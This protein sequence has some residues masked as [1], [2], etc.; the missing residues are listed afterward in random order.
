MPC[1][2]NTIVLV[3]MFK[4]GAEPMTAEQIMKQ[5]SRLGDESYKKTMLRHGASGPIFGVKIEELKKIQ[6]AIKKDYK[7]ALELFDSGNSDAMYLAGLIADEQ[8]MTKKDLEHWAATASWHMI[9]EYTVSWVA[10][11]SKFGFEL[12]KKWIDSKK[13]KVALAGWGTLSSLVSVKPDEELNL[14]ELGALLDRVAVDIH[15]APDR[16]RYAMN[17]FII[18]VGSYV[19]P[20]TNHALEV[21]RQVGKV[22]V[23]MGD[24]ACK[25]PGAAEYIGKVAKAGRIGR[26]RKTARC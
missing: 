6:K 1:Q 19:E 21:A 15:K 7:L 24:T 22:T 17:A 11:E 8:Q 20:L 9:S 23:D 4:T 26:K 12:A 25:V 2:L 3:P 10:S 14:K 13:E 16:V 5:L 18:S